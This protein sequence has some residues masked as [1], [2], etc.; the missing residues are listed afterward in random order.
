MDETLRPL[1]D[2]C[3]AYIDN[4]TIFDKTLPEHVDHLDQVFKKLLER[5]ISVSPKKS[6]IGYPCAT[7]LGQKVNAFGLQ[8]TEE[9]TKALVEMPFPRT[10]KITRCNYPSP[11]LFIQK[12]KK[13]RNT[14]R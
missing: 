5:N 6:F 7:L 14:Y 2:F 1:R 11:F 4:I 8:S 3:R 13:K 12:K 10:L 9:R